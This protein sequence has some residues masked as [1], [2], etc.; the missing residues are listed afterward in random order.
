MIEFTS[1]RHAYP[2]QSGFFIDRPNGHINYT[3][4]HFFNSVN[5]KYN[6]DLITTKPDAV[7]IYDIGTPQFFQS[8]APLVHDWMHIKGDLSLILAKYNLKTD[9]IYYPK[10]PNFIT[11]LTY[12]LAYEYYSNHDYNQTLLNLKFEELIIKLSRALNEQ[13]IPYLSFETKANFQSLRNKMLSDFSKHWTT[14]E[15]ANEVGFSQSRFYHIY[16]S[17]Y[18]IP[19]TNDIINARIEKAKYLLFCEKKSV[20]ET[21]EM[22]GYDNTTHFIR[23]FRS[24]TRYSPTE[25]KKKH[26]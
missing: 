14:E 24:K 18:G 12:E 22:L 5:I 10:K 26:K 15:M 16:K 25:Y 8:P 20:A 9:T 23:Q 19:P 17:L 2:E 1:L 7:I 6:G 21:A 11:E 4:L 3:F 13:S